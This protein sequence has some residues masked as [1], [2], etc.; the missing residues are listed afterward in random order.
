[1]D[2]LSHFFLGGGGWDEISPN[3]FHLGL[4]IQR[5]SCHELNDLFILSFNARVL[6]YYFGANPFPPHT[7]KLW[8]NKSPTPF[9]RRRDISYGPTI[10]VAT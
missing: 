7:L 4:C 1:M 9:Q 6:Y 5:C 2:I 3:F 10:Y 8:G